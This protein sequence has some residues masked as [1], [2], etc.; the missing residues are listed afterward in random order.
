M[1]VENFADHS[2]YIKK[3]LVH[4]RISEINFYHVSLEEIFYGCARPDLRGVSLYAPSETGLSP[5]LEY[6]YIH[7]DCDVAVRRNKKILVSGRDPV[8]DR[9]T[10]DG[11]PLS[12]RRDFSYRCVSK[13]LSF[14]LITLSTGST[15]KP[16][17]N[18]VNRT[19][20][21][22]AVSTK[23]HLFKKIFFSR[24][25]IRARWILASISRYILLPKNI[26][27]LG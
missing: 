21:A 7:T 23:F 8:W 14:G 25:D 26:A 18:R 6:I 11:E 5:A 27:S 22:I 16:A 19:S 15:H 17:S 12:R 10:S 1:T 24:N 13:F 3:K 9:S 20:F 2:L 4:T